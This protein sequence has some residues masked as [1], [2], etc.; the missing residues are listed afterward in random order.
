MRRR[1]WV[2][3]YRL[4]DSST[5]NESK[6]VTVTA[7]QLRKII[8]DSYYCSDVVENLGLNVL[9]YNP[10]YGYLADGYYFESPD[11]E[12]PERG[13]LLGGE[14]LENPAPLLIRVFSRVE[15]MPFDE[16]A[17]IS[18]RRSELWADIEVGTA[19]DGR[20]VII[21]ISELLAALQASD[22]ST[23]NFRSNAVA[24]DTA[25]EAAEWLC[26]EFMQSCGA[27]VASKDMPFVRE[28]MFELMCEAWD[29][30][31]QQCRRRCKPV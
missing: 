10:E 28:L 11:I 2:Q 24:A 25:D 14:V 18:W 21:E 15:D 5:G 9:D 22:N 13:T 20:Q 6:T 31:N 3:D 29:S 4:L 8:A 30:G 1:C 23:A 27:R 19:G 12:L 26:D 17:C 16:V 7:R